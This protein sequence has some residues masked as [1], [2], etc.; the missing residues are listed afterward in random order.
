M[1][2]IKTDTSDYQKLMETYSINSL[3]AKVLSAMKY[4]EHEIASFYPLTEFDLTE[5]VF[6]P[7]K[8]C[9]EKIKREN[10][11][12]SFLVIM[13]VMEFVLQRLLKRY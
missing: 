3:L 7:I 2:Y 4:D 12:F 6:E 9:L 10:K 5:E 1:I 8:I 11:K 13:I